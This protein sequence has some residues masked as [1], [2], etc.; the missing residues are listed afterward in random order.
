M[1]TA[2]KDQGR[3]WGG[4]SKSGRFAERCGQS[5]TRTAIPGSDAGRPRGSRSL[6]NHWS[7]RC[8]LAV[9]Q[10]VSQRWKGYLDRPRRNVD[11]AQQRCL[12]SGWHSQ[13]SEN[14]GVCREDRRLPATRS[15]LSRRD[16]VLA[17]N[18]H[19]VQPPFGMLHK[20]NLLTDNSQLEYHPYTRPDCELRTK[21]R[22]S[23]QKGSRAVRQS[24]NQAPGA[25]CAGVHTRQRKRGQCFKSSERHSKIRRDSLVRCL[26]HH[27]CERNLCRQCLQ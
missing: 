17:A 2:T 15:I 25:H 16:T 5:A 3:R 14:E 11:P 19:S 27:R 1:R 6:P 12:C 21:G 4:Q 23:G 24:R 20:Y 18:D 13:I 22:R 7:Y 26:D 8:P 9:S 10:S